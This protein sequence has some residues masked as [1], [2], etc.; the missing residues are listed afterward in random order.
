M[1]KKMKKL[2]L[3]IIT[4][5]GLSFSSNLYK[6]IY[7][8][9][10]L[11]ISLLGDSTVYLLPGSEY[12]ELGAQAYDSIDGDI[13]KDIIIDSSTIN[14]SVEG[15]Y[16][17]SYSITN[18]SSDSMTIYR[19]VIVDDFIEIKEKDNNLYG[20]YQKNT[21]NKLIET[22]DG[23]FLVVGKAQDYWNYS[24]GYVMKFD[25]NMDEIWSKPGQFSSYSSFCDVIETNNKYIVIDYDYYY[26]RT[27]VIVYSEG[28]TI[29]SNN[30]ING[31]YT[32]I[33]SI[34]ENNYVLLSDGS[35]D[36]CLV[37]FSSSFK[38][39][40]IN[41][42]Y[43]YK[44]N[45]GGFISNDKLYFIDSTN[46]IIEYNFR[47]NSSTIIKQADYTNIY[48]SD[49]IYAY[50]NG[51]YV[52]K[53]DNDFNEVSKIEL[54]VSKLN[55]NH[56]QD[57]LV[58]Q[59]TSN[60]FTYISKNNFEIIKECYVD[61]SDFYLMNDFIVINDNSIMMYGTKHNYYNY[62]KNVNFNKT[63][64]DTTSETFDLNTSINYSDYIQIL[65]PT[66][67]YYIQNVDSSE[68]DTS[69]AGIYNVYYILKYL[70]SDIKTIMGSKEIII[71]HSTSI[72][73]EE[74]FQGSVLIDVEGAQVTVN[75][76][77]YAY[78][79]SFSWPG[80]NEMTITGLNG[81]EK[82][83]QFYIE[84]TIDGVEEGQIY[85]ESVTP[86]ISGGYLTLDGKEY[87]NGTQ[88]T[89]KGYHRLDINYRKIYTIDESVTN[90]NF[91]NGVYTSQNKRE[92][93]YY[94]FNDNVRFF[95]INFTEDGSFEFNY[96]INAGSYD[97]LNIL[98]ND[99][100]I[101]Y[102]SGKE[103]I[104]SKVIE[105]KAGDYLECYYSHKSYNYTTGED[106]AYFEIAKYSTINFTIEPI[107]TGVED[108]QTYYKSITPQIDAENMTLNGVAYNNEQISNCGNYELVINGSGGYSKTIN[109]VIEAIV[110]NLI[111]EGIY[112]ESVTPTF[113]KGEALLNGN[114][115]ISGTK[116]STPGYNTLLINGEGGYILEFNFTINEKIEG[117]ENS[118]IYRGSV[119]PKIS[120]GILKLNGNDYISETIIDVPG[121][122]TL[123]IF[124]ASDYVKKIIFV[125]RPEQVNVSNESVYNHS[126]IPAISKG[127]LKLNGN[128]YVSG[129]VVNKSGDYTLQIIGE[130][131]YLETINFTLKT[132][133]NVED[134]K[135][136]VDQLTLHFVGEGTLNDEA[137]IAGTLL[138]KIGNYTLK[139]IDGENTYTY[140]FKI[141]P[142]YS[143]FESEIIK[144]FEFTYSNAE[145]LLNNE[146][147]LSGTKMS[148]VGNY[149]L[150]VLGINGYINSIDFAIHPS[151]N[152]EDGIEYT[153]SK[154][155]IINGGKAT[156]NGKSINVFSYVSEIGNHTLVITGIND[157][158]KTINFSIAPVFSGVTDFECY[159]ESVIPT[160]NHNNLK[161]NNEDYVSGSEISD[162]G[163]YKLEILGCNDYKK[164]INFIILPSDFDILPNQY[165]V[166]E[167]LISTCDASIKI[168]DIDYTSNTKITEYGK[169]DLK[170]IYNGGYSTYSFYIIPHLEGVINNGIY[171]SSV[172]INTEYE[173]LLLNNNPYTSGT[174]ITEVG[175]H[176]LILK[177]LNGYDHK[178]EFT[179]TETYK[180]ISNNASYQGSVM[181][182]INGG[183]LTLD[184][185]A[186]VSG[187]TIEEVGHHTLTITGL[188]G[189]T[190][191][192]NFTVCEE[193]GE[194]EFNKEYFESVLI[195]IPNATL[196]LNFQPFTNNTI[197]KTVGNH[198][199]S[200]LGTNG[201]R[202]DYNFVITPN[203]KFYADGNYNDFINGQSFQNTNYIYLM[204]NNV[205]SILL[206]DNLY[207]SG[208]YIY[209]IGN[210]E[211]TIYGVNGYTFDLYFTKEVDLS[212]FSTNE[213]IPYKKI[214][215]KNTVLT[216]L[217]GEDIPNS[218]TIYTIGNHELKIYGVGD[219]IKTISFVIHPYLYES[220]S[221][222]SES[223]TEF[224]SRNGAIIRLYNKLQ[225][226]T[227]SDEYYEGIEIDGIEYT[228]NTYYHL[229]GNHTLTVYGINNYI[230]ELD[231][232]I[233]PTITNI[234]E[235]AETIRFKPEIY[236]NSSN[237]Y[238]DENTYVLLDGIQFTLNTNIYDVGYHK[239]SIH[240]SGDYLLEIN[241][242][243]LPY[244][245]NLEENKTYT[246]P[247][248]PSVYN[249]E[250]LLNKKPYA[251]GTI[252]NE[253]GNHVLTVIGCNGYSKDYHF[254][255]ES[256]NVNNY[257]YRS[258]VSS[259]AITDIEY[260]EIFVNGIKYTQGDPIDT[261]GH[262][263]IEIKGVNNYSSKFN[264]T[265][266]SSPS[267]RTKEG[268]ERITNNFIS[269]GMVALNIPKAELLIDGEPYESDSEYY[270]VGR[271]YLEILGLGGYKEEYSFTIQANVIGLENGA[272]YDSLAILCEHTE[273]I[274]LND[275]TIENGFNVNNVGTY[276]LTIK[277]SNGYS[278]NYN[279][280]INKQ[281]N[282][283]E[284]NKIYYETVTPV[285]NS[286]DAILNGQPYISGT[287]INDVGNYI[288]IINGEGGYKETVCFTIKET[289]SGIN[290]DDI[291]D[292][293][294]EI[295]IDG[296]CKQIILNDK[297][298]SNTM[299]ANQ[300]GFNVLKIIGL[301]GYESIIEFTIEPIIEG[302]ENAETYNELKT[303]I[304]TGVCESIRLNNNVVSNIF[305]ANEVGTNNLIIYGL[306]NYTKSISFN[307][308][309][310]VT[311]I[312][313]EQSYNG[314]TEVSINFYPKSVL[315]NG[316]KIN[317]NSIV[318]NTLKI[319][320]VGYNKLTIE[321]NNGDL[322]E[323][324]FLI[325]P[326]INNLLNEGT[327]S[328]NII[329]NIIGTLQD[330]KLN[331]E[332][333]TVGSSI[334]TVGF[335]NLV[336]YGL[337]N[338]S[339]TFEFTIEPILTN[340]PN[341]P[342][343]NFIPIIE[344]DCEVYINGEHIEDSKNNMPTIDIVGTNLVEIRGKNDYSKV[345]EID[346]KPI[347]KGV[348]DNAEDVV[349]N[350]EVDGD[351]LVYLDNILT[352]NVINNY[353]T[354]GNHTLLIRGLN[355]YEYSIDF[356]V[357]E[358]FVINSKYTETFKLSY[359]SGTIKIDNQIYTSDSV[360]QI[361]GNHT[362]TIEGDNDY[363]KEYSMCIEPVVKGIDN[364]S[365]IYVGQIS[366]E[367]P[368]GNILII[369]DIQ[370]TNKCTYNEIGNHTLVINGAN[371]YLYSYDFIIKESCSIEET[372]YTDSVVISIDNKYSYLQLDGIL[373]SN[374][375]S[376]SD[377]GNHI[378]EIIGSN[379][380]ITTYYFNI[381]PS[382]EGVVN[383]SIYNYS[384]S[385]NIGGM[386]NIELDGESVEQTGSCSTVGHHTFKIYSDYGY[387]QTLFFTILP[388][389]V[390]VEHEGV[391]GENRSIAIPNCTLILNGKQIDNYYKISDIGYHNIQILGTNGYTENIDFT[392]T[393]NDLCF[394]NGESYDKLK[395]TGLS[396]CKLLLD[397]ESIVNNYVVSMPG[398]HILTI[399]GTNG[400]FKEYTFYIN[401]V[402]VYNSQKIVTNGGD[403]IVN[404]ENVSQG[405]LLETIGNNKITLIGSNGHTVEKEIFLSENMSVS[406]GA[407][408]LNRVLIEKVEAQVF[409]NGVE[410]FEDTY[411][412]KEGEHVI[413]IIGVGG[414]EKEFTIH[415]TNTNK[416][417]SIVCSSISGLAIITIAITLIRRKKV[418]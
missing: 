360:Y 189:Y 32:N 251:T 57:Y 371:N 378:L 279:F 410:I 85:Y 207:S 284:N 11:T 138:N 130:A 172:T 331:G 197:L 119:T 211:L 264:I 220:N 97:Y 336:L 65:D 125:V 95:K 114:P 316:N 352:T 43:L 161:L 347:I 8:D 160:I 302:I 134:G 156:L 375:H 323:Y 1:M 313:N 271:H 46:N 26:N 267:V 292:S 24:Y 383:N 121:N 194:L 399:V 176:V 147:Y 259:V 412:E 129:T 295:L 100:S 335:N 96:W 187:T 93:N 353:T 188:N 10:G 274:L 162:P 414:Y 332:T 12:I 195:N 257:A 254:Q 201:Y 326:V 282:G 346:I 368:S 37:D 191:N 340:N 324:E 118:Q 230:Y 30:V 142:D 28:G 83:I 322:Y 70:D 289:I 247:V 179:I 304:I 388:K 233:N 261:I 272:T 249:C 221:Y 303:I 42:G 66:I 361:I 355:N 185:N 196:E 126:V 173:Y 75:G 310:Q 413:K 87:I 136:Y 56:N 135:S 159:F 58:A 122:Y 356:I 333:I 365:N 379:G 9:E 111:D 404:G 141:E 363:I 327:Y 115:Y 206:N 59:T 62:I 113:N 239:I 44:N 291:I 341:E 98:L 408:Y 69:K 31:K 312:E 252:I 380:Y 306:N 123:E 117:V 394:E 283:V 315:I 168:D 342:V 241:F 330:L 293:E 229:V 411:I 385:W 140:N 74:K 71:E 109:F 409:I 90:Y 148:E 139:L 190:N 60:T 13:S 406:N 320:T 19:T 54:S 389:I 150:K 359:S 253:L 354:I 275:I 108:G 392:I 76:V 48:L 200:V 157:Y 263:E 278:E 20:L 163:I 376:C 395:L 171:D 144:N 250:L 393:E 103:E 174:P 321:G 325:E 18:S 217:N 81:Y 401:F 25:E 86:N 258:F 224:Y 38:Y 349:F 386:A 192:I 338:Y 231:F 49:Y 255:I 277:G 92:N 400:Y 181:P 367:I 350:I 288:L 374:N 418:I 276:Y 127:T 39:E 415:I 167:A 286:D 5:I 137:I 165:F 260:C 133:A 215:F 53:L 343:Y 91:I 29:V 391:Y 213:D 102:I 369:D 248:T 166:E 106:T 334:N 328:G 319:N 238:S 403:I 77:S 216:Q 269:E 280:F 45:Y 358:D 149:T 240:G 381:N 27:R 227:L 116:I 305:T 105:V 120:G 384:M 205:E 177:N 178:I 309:P 4:I 182:L 112:D 198:T 146:L 203:Y 345:F 268:I 151:V 416:I 199:L 311:G 262:N 3:I 348:T 16:K 242:T 170:L 222:I 132:G 397:G 67:T 407:E 79:D 52:V 265:I 298:V 228:N 152:V 184:G 273:S 33:I 110:E 237:D 223:K 344:G 36:A 104:T 23:N 226:T 337:G 84:P 243:I 210:Y 270:K 318:N 154:F 21:W 339:K 218:T 372:A 88:I 294:V 225:G 64:L 107:V 51:E 234:Y 55:I 382:I 308:I 246:S 297:T 208:N 299:L 377:I 158:V 202:Q 164:V 219:Y 61:N 364:N 14:N 73:N 131:G 128:D 307:L 193:P 143:I 402:F 7:A 390:G 417:F 351:C 145:V 204:V 82:T 301:N 329:P 63:S 124:G 68:V 94:Y 155:L 317:S 398:K 212:G 370:Q 101:V 290:N 175:N 281:L 22:S 314:Y 244:I 245:L 50:K 41:L 214:D 236:L 256:P 186:Y 183:T 17:V 80:K 153:T 47:E 89:E 366:L 362:V 6:V 387:E 396:N 296:N 232:T 40:N 300:V 78:G 287:P 235:D 266:I 169:H 373:I 2:L 34:N 15:T 285:F 99:S 180:N 357:K 209:D 405:Y 72:E 35:S